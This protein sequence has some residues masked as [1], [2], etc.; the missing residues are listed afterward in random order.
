MGVMR[1]FNRDALGFIERLQRDYGDIV[2]SRFLYVPA[3]F[4]YHPNEIESVLTTNAKKF[5]ESDDAEVK[6][7]SATGGQ[8]VVDQRR[9]GVEAAAPAVESGISP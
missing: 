3:L 4:L 8:R 6:L 2:W 5:P 7:L 9:R 1:E